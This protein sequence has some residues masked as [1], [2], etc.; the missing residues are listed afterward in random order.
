MQKPA[1][2]PAVILAR[3]NPSMP[4]L[5][6][7]VV[8]H[9]RLTSVEASILADGTRWTASTAA[10]GRS[11]LGLDQ[12]VPFCARKLLFALSPTMRVLS[13]HPRV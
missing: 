6:V 7:V 8:V 13:V 10:G 9:I 5:L 4:V 1:L 3:S 11:S 2:D 12:S